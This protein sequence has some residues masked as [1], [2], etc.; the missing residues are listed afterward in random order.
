[1][2]T[3]SPKARRHSGSRQRLVPVK[4]LVSAQERQAFR[5]ASIEE[6]SSMRRMGRRLIADWLS[7]RQEAEG[8]E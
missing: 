6:G 5:I 3:T 1:M 8:S 2:G 7:T 4:V